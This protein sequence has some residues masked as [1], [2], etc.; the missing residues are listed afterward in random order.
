ML[1]YSSVQ[2]G[3]S[4]RPHDSSSKLS[5][6]LFQGL[7]W[8]YDISSTDNFSLTIHMLLIFSICAKLLYFLVSVELLEYFLPMKSTMLL[9]FLQSNNLTCF[10]NFLLFTILYTSYSLYFQDNFTSFLSDST[11]ILLVGKARDF[12]N[13]YLFPF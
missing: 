10:T 3:F 7:I 2:C 9:I 13:S 5:Y 4:Y 8:K 11:V 6:T 1:V 12:P